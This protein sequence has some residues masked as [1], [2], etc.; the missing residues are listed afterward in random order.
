MKT[1]CIIALKLI[2][3]QGLLAQTMSY[4][5]VS[6]TPPK[7]WK[8]EE[9]KTARVYSKIDGGSWAQI[10]IYKSTAT[11][12]N[13]D[14]DFDSEWKNLVVSSFNISEKPDKTKAETADGWTVM[15]GSGV[16]KYNGSNVA[17]I[18]TTYSGHGLCLS[19]LHNATAQ[20][21]LRDYKKFIGTVT[22]KAPPAQLRPNAVVANPH[23]NNLNKYVWRS[24]QKRNTSNLDY[25]AYNKQHY[26]FR[27]DGTYAFYQESMQSYTP[28]Y[29]LINETGTYSWKGD[30]ITLKPT[31]SQWSQHQNQKTDK[32]LKSN[33][34]NFPNLQYRV[35]YTTIYDRSRLVLWPIDGKENERDGTFNYYNN[36]E[37]QKAY[38][39]DAEEALVSTAREQS[40]L[41]NTALVGMWID[42]MNETSGTFPDGKPR[43]TSG[44]FRRE[45]RFFHD[46]TYKFLKKDFAVNNKHIFFTHETGRWTTTG[47]QLTITPLQGE[48]ETWTKS[49]SGHT[50]EW[51]SLQKRKKRKLEKV[52]Y[53]YQTKS[54]DGKPSLVLYRDKPTERETYENKGDNKLNEWSYFSR[55]INQSL[56]DL[57][58]GHE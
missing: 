45:Y 33:S 48:Y 42:Y 56:I 22:L 19:I 12:G 53:N 9:Q 4:D 26:E 6:Y 20:P 18:L 15:S 47:D 1:L 57:P 30:I 54:S 31:K 23:A 16:W 34:T 13:I 11:K 8:V 49:P 17:T 46:G 28:K 29:Y 7:G 44:Y 35:S 10:G 55:P 41:V 3:M 27:P 40:H 37:L 5:I 39:Y 21:Y 25:H 32:A 52:V 38:L 14:A 43:Y 36:G 58:P 2:L 24:H 51:G 50:K